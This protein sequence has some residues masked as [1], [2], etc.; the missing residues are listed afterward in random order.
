[1][2]HNIPFDVQEIP[3]A[4]DFE[5]DLD[6]WTDPDVPHVNIPDDFDWSDSMDLTGAPTTYLM[7]CAAAMLAR[8]GQFKNKGT[9]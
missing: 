5:H 6:H 1:M 4:M 8:S 2:F 7:P 9:L 3:W